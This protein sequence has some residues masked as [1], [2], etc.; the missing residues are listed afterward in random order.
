[1][2]G[3]G[4]AFVVPPPG[5]GGDGGAG[6][7]GAAVLAV[8]A[9]D[10]VD[11]DDPAFVRG[12]VVAARSV[13]SPASSVATALGGGGG[14]MSRSGPVVGW[15]MGALEESV[16]A[17][18]GSVVDGEALTDVAEGAATVAATRT[19]PIDMTAS[20]AVQGTH[21]GKRRLFPGTIAVG[22]WRRARSSE[23]AGRGGATSAR[24]LS[25]W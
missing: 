18:L 3:V 7:T 13:G 19:P 23:V 10:V 16:V 15:A 5:D 12:V 24:G 14:G 21:A 25:R 8:E 4:G 2:A 9:R 6:T 20:M 22:K 17:A 1:V 11:P